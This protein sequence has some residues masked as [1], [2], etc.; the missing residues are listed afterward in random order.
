MIKSK[1]IIAMSGGVDSSVAAF[2]MQQQGYDCIGV[3]MKLFQGNPSAA[4]SDETDNEKSCCSLNDVQDARNVAC[5]LG[6][7][8][9][10]FNFSSEFNH[11][12]IDRFI[13]DYQNGRTP[14]PCVECNR[15][16][17]FAKLLHR[18]NELQMDYVVTGHYAQI[19]YDEVSKRYLLKKAVDH[20]KDQSY[21]LYMLTQ[22]QLAHVRFPLGG[23]EKAEVRRIAEENGFC[24]ARKH[25]SQDI[26]FVPDGDYVSFI[27][28]YT[29]TA[30][31]PGNYI[32]PDGKVLGTHKGIIHYTIGQRKGLGIALGAPAY[33]TDLDP[34]ANT[35]TLGTNDD[36]FSC[37]LTADQVNL[38]SCDSLS[39][40]RRVLARVRYRHRE[41]PALAWQTEDG[42]LHVLF[43][44]PQ[45]AITKGQA[46]VLYDGDVVVGG[47]TITS[48]SK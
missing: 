1:A 5:R 48:V 14:N 43:D 24:N 32:S 11:A 37:K 39:A 9:Y 34:T 16:L 29:H 27:E 12:V 22:E 45:R 3:T 41:Q 6:M 2:L 23:M 10:V 26:C 42:T 20:Q 21:F 18:M 19:V 8:F 4:D 40:P 36:L 28:N 35:V 46:V 38:I 30:S 15:C 7:P 33:V 44:E 47:G 31:I 17:K 13:S 25:D